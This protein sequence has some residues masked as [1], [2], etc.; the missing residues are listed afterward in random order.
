V[1]FGH[2]FLRTTM[3]EVGVTVEAAVRHADTIEKELGR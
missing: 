1:P 3:A 2:P